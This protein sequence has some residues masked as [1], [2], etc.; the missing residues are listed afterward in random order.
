MEETEE[1]PGR[2][3]S[4]LIILVLLLLLGGF[5]TYFTIQIVK[6]HTIQQELSLG[7]H[8]YKEHKYKEAII[9]YK[10]VL[11]IDPNNVEA[12]IGLAKSYLALKMYKP[13]VQV[14]KAG[15][16]L[17]PDEPRLYLGLSDTDLARGDVLAAI[18][19]LDNGY[20]KT[21][22]G[23][24]ADKLG[25]M[26]QSISIESD[27]N[28]VQI[29][30]SAHLKTIYKKSPDAKGE[31][32]EASWSLIPGDLGNLSS[33]TGKQNTFTGNK[34]GD[35]SVMAKMGSISEQKNIKVSK[36]VLTSLQI[37]TS[38]TQATPGQRIQLK[39]VGKDADG[40]TFSV[41]PLWSV[42]SGA[43]DLS[44]Q[45]G[46]TVYFSSEQTGTAKV[47][48]EANGKRDTVT[49]DVNKAPTPST[50][51]ASDAAAATGS[52]QLEQP[53][54]SSQPVAATQTTQLSQ[55]AAA[56]TG[57]D[58]LHPQSGSATRPVTA[59]PQP[60]AT[61][62]IASGG[63]TTHSLT[64]S[65]P[66]AASPVGPSAPASSPVAA[67]PQPVPSNPEQPAPT[68]QP[69]G[70]I[71]GTITDAQSGAPVSGATVHVLNADGS[72]AASGTTDQNGN[73]TIAALKPGTYTVN[74]SGTDYVTKSEQITVMSGATTSQNETIIK[75]G[76]AAF[77]VVLTWDA[78]PDD[79][80][81]HLAWVDASDPSTTNQVYYGN[82]AVQDSNGT[83]LAEL[84][85]DDT[86]AYGPETITSFQET[87]G[88][89]YRYFVYNF[90][91]GNDTELSQSQAEVEL[92]RD[93]H[94]VK[95][96]NVP[97]TGNGYVW[98][99]FEI[100]DGTI[101]IINTIDASDPDY[102]ESLSDPETTADSG[103]TGSSAPAAA[104]STNSA[105]TDSSSST[106]PSASADSSD[107][108]QLESD[109][110][111]PAAATSSQPSDDGNSSSTAAAS[112]QPSDSSSTAASSSAPVAP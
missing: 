55:T 28:N 38:T 37:Q 87:P 93:G 73:Y 65:Q 110:S 9:A 101:R 49:L 35:E 78:E 64:G 69:T 88:T 32:V 80:D 76:Q 89:T 54:Q 105:T 67:T 68:P 82:T 84:D 12:R 43:G 75:Q 22:D 15:I 23:Q 53:A 8:Y 81:S 104:D 17:L 3:R 4:I 96:L 10:K 1:K 109:S 40:K 26:S 2:K 30:T 100:T 72:E 36:H 98:H 24:F 103:D 97:T 70:G 51:N 31:L 66:T 25:Q 90:S 48:A 79:L 71:S 60:V 86:D 77:Q 91:H 18:R 99:V 27:K 56:T 11:S 106:A 42:T 107:P 108:S 5:G 57:T 63:T 58:V 34:N 21:K 83:T 62:P 85:H 61:Q 46:E 102:S 14:L 16:K 111:S 52:T 74:Y 44:A 41:N 6:Q 7:N 33:K 47:T 19:D 50:E 112:Q 94:L 29:G 13:A 39:A 92:Y 59:T 20:S 95:T 45:E